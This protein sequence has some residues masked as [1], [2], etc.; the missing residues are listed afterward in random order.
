MVEMSGFRV[1]GIRSIIQGLGA[2]GRVQGVR[3]A[4]A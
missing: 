4:G 2:R 1:Q 3:G